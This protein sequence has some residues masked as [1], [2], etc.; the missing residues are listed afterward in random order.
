MLGIFIIPAFFCVWFHTSIAQSTDVSPL[1]L[2]CPTIN[3]LFAFVVVLSA[4]RSV[5][6]VF[7]SPADYRAPNPVRVRSEPNLNPVLFD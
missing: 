2:L 4:S 5:W 6:E 7:T 1:L 3:F